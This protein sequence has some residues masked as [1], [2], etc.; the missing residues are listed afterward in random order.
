MMLAI[1]RRSA[2]VVLTTLA[3]LS[4][5]LAR[6][7]AETVE[8]IRQLGPSSDD[9]S[10]GVSADGLGNVYI[11]GGTDGSLGGPNAGSADA[12]VARIS[13]VVVPE[14][15]SWVLLVLAAM[16]LLLRGRRTI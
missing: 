7:Q 10:W 9:W 14:P 5:P 16:P 1:H 6:G 2:W 4:L 15:A 8:W 3:C 12:F 11:S 13:D